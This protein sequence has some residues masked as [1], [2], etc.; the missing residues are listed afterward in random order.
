MKRSK[1]VR[2]VLLGSVPFV[3]V[4]CDGQPQ[5]TREVRQTQHFSS[6]RDCV[7]AQVPSAIC[8]AAFDDARERGELIAPRY[9]DL[10]RCEDDF[11]AGN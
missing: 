11:F 7:L 9:L 2:L 8:Q 5:A 4:A 3:L 10:Q 1:S 6:V